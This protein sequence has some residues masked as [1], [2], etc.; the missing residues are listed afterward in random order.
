VETKVFR[1]CVPVSKGGLLSLAVSASG[2][3]FG[4]G[5]AP[6]VYCGCGD[7]TLK[8]LQG[9]DLQWTCL[10]ET[11]LDGII[12][13][14][15][16]SADQTE[17]LAGTSEGNLYRLD[18][19]TLM[20]LDAAGQPTNAALLA[21]HPNAITCLG[22]GDSSEWFISA[23][24]T[25]VM[26]RWELSHYTVQYEVPAPVKT[27]DADNVSHAHCVV[28]SRESVVP[29]VAPLTLSGWSDGNIRAY[30]PDNG[31]F[32]WQMVGAH[33]GGVT[34]I[35]YTPTYL[36]SGGVD[37]SIRIWSN[38]ASRKLVGNFDEHKK[39]VT[40]MC[41]DVLRNKLVHSCGDDKNVVTIDLDQA[42]RV[43]CHAAKEGGFRSMVQSQ[44]GELELITADSMGNLKWWDSDEWEPVS[45]AV[46]WSPAQDPNKDRRLTHIDLSPP[47]AEGE[48]GCDFLTCCTASGDLQVWDL[49]RSQCVSIG[50]AHSDEISEARWAP[51][52]KQIVSVGKD[53]CICVWNFY[54]SSL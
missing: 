46:T 13:S 17:L 40:G 26:R 29:G 37:G 41:V 23:S 30:E 10:H 44:V 35:C 42:R 28:V 49:R 43:N 16:L 50:S 36:V 51:D 22:F 5:S 3:K 15:T 45:M 14:L 24:V 38:E 32:L 21:S 19:E 33:R 54:S 8:L 11:Q 31:A 53:A 34:C 47:M 4:D 39:R 6:L 48:K 27:T 9:F 7:G 12:R 52:G 18:A 25:G 2:G 1:A 20:L